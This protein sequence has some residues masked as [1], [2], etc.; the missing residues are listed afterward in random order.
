M[1]YLRSAFSYSSPKT[2]QSQPIPNTTQV[3][4]NAGGY[5][6]AID[7]WKRLN[8]FLILGSEGGT[9]YVTESKLILENSTAVRKCIDEDGL[10]V[11]KEVAEVSISGRAPKNDPALFV[12]AMCC[13]FG[14]QDTKKAAFSILTDV[15]RIGTHLFHFVDFCVGHDQVHKSR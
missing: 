14:N 5:T 12:L 2:P 13:A 6:W 11:V 7:H 4:N 15:A 9:Y 3:P 10:R 8:R 1:T